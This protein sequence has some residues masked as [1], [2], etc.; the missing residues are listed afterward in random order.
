MVLFLFALGAVAVALY[1]GLM[2]REVPGFA[3]QRLGR[4]EELP[5]D[6]GTWRVDKETAQGREA[7]ARGESREVR[8][9]FE[10]DDGLLSAGAFT[11]QARYR[12]AATGAI[13]RSDPD[14]VTKRR[15]VRAS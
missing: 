8:T 4:L 14:R 11:H 2:L 6:L 9:L 15:R 12:D 1:V 5:A 3:E 7:I 10:P 13:L